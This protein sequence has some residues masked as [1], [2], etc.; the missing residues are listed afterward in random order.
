MITREGM[1]TALADATALFQMRSA[2]VSL[3]LALGLVAAIGIGAWTRLG[4]RRQECS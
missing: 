1:E 2:M 4:Q 3:G